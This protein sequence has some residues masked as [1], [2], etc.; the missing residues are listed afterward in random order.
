[1]K[2]YNDKPYRRSYGFPNRS[3]IKYGINHCREN[4]VYN[5]RFGKDH[6]GKGTFKN[7]DIVCA[8]ISRYYINNTD[9]DVIIKIPIYKRRNGKLIPLSFRKC[10][11][12][13]SEYQY[14][15]KKHFVKSAN[16]VLRIPI[17][18][19]MYKLKIGYV[20]VYKYN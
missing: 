6:Y 13:S 7:K 14:T 10:R 4:I 20:F 18:L 12:Y 16:E 8:I 11:L 15:V 9:D 3:M 2:L 19:K 1:M 17:I 5:Y